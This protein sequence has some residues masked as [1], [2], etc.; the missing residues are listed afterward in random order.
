MA[1]E[2][3]IRVLLA[4]PGLDGHDRGISAVFGPGTPIKAIADFV[5]KSIAEAQTRTLSP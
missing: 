5:K 1:G 4:K 2:S 3:K